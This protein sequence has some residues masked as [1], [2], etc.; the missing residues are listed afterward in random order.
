MKVARITFAT[1]LLCFFGI[2]FVH[3]QYDPKKD[4]SKDNEPARKSIEVKANLMVLNADG[5]FADIKL[6]DLKI[7]EDGAEQKINYLVKKENALN[8]GL[9]VDNTNS[10][11]SQLAGITTASMTLVNNLRPQDETFL[12]RFVSSDK[13][14]IWQDWTPSKKLL[15]DSLENL[16]VE[17]G[18]SAVIDGLY[19]SA[20]RLLEREKIDRSKRSALILISDGE[21]RDSY[22]NQKELFDLLKT[23]DVQ[24]FII[25]LTQDLSDKSNESTKRKNSKTDSENFIKLLALKTGGAAFIVEGKNKEFE[26][27]LV[28]SLKSI[29]TELNSQFVIGYTSTNQKRDGTARKLTVQV[30]VGAKDEKRRAFIR[31]SFVVPK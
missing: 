14:E 7:Y 3:S 13:V 16:Y 25:G 6:E 24:I 2:S 26:N 27:A 8:I 12:V 22:Y 4:R 19:L 29:L 31:E 28:Q 15:N 23:S 30:A 1:L 21:D 20:S 11:R 10:M 5:K 9:V 17:D 18:A